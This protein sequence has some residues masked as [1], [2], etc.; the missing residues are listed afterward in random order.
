MRRIIVKME[1][2]LVVSDLDG[3]LLNSDK[4][5][6]NKNR[7]AIEALRERG[8]F[9]AIA[10][11]RSDL[12]TKRY[13]SELDITTPVIACNGGLIKDMHKDEIIHRQLIPMPV[14]LAV[15]DYCNAKQW[16]YLVYTPEIIYYTEKSSRMEFIR[17][18][19]RSVIED[20]KVSIRPISELLKEEKEQILA[21][22]LE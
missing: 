20:L 12:L 1:Y 6:S 22:P 9:F 21:T 7:R 17:E 8:I 5:V 18:Y 16:D 11:G 2:K 3:T 19:N 13:I 15:I 10:T 14:A 4:E